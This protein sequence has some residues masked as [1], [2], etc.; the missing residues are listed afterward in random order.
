MSLV[1]RILTAGIYRKRIR[2]FCSRTVVLQ[3][4]NVAKPSY[5]RLGKLTKSE[6]SFG[7]E[8]E[9]LRRL[10][11][12]NDFADFFKYSLFCQRLTKFGLVFLLLEGQRVKFD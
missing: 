4:K 5:R 1:K 8:L 12:V 9:N 3:T 6:K 11:T 10:E 2:N 7:V